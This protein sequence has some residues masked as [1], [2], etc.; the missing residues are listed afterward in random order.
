MWTYKREQTRFSLL[1]RY[2]ILSRSKASENRLSITN[3]TVKFDLNSVMRAVTGVT[4][5]TQNEGPT[6]VPFHKAAM[7][8]FTVGVVCC[9]C[10]NNGNGLKQPE[11]F[12]F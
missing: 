5:S 9:F 8:L 1:L 2:K 6:T 4:A 11:Y 7:A 10:F 3:I 12:V